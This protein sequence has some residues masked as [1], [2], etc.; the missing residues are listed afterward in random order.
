MTTFPAKR[1][2]AFTERVLIALGVAEADAA[3]TAELLV[4]ADLRGYSTHGIGILPEYVQRSRAGTIRLN[5]KPAVVHDS[6]AAAQIDGDLYLGQVVGTRAMTL[7]VEKAHAHGV[8]MVGVRNCAHLGRIADYVELAADAGMIGMAFVSV[9]GASL[10]TFGSAEP[11]GNSDPIAFGIPGPNG[12]HLIFDFTTAAMSMRELARRGAQGE[13]IPAGIMLDHAGNPTTDY[14][15]F[16][17][18]PRGVALPFGGHKG[19]G[20]HL[21]AEVLAGILTG[22]GTG[23]SWAARGGPAINGALFFAVDVADMMPLD[24]FLEEVNALAAFLRSC[25]PMAGVTAIRLP[26][27]GARVR[28]SE[29]RDRGIPLDDALVSSLNA[30]AESLGVPTLA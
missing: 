23:L 24:E 26:G 14:A 11:T 8:G 21:V 15:Q 20:L 2:V 17:G 13:P 3:L 30:T 12:Q 27:D 25:R 7:A 9:G 6:K 1:L 19:S 4:R 28:A 10:A 22:H 29:R 16:A 18:P 5:G